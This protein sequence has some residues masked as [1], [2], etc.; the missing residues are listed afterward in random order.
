[1][2]SSHHSMYAL[3]LC[4]PQLTVMSQYGDGGSLSRVITSS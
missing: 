4:W 2:V 1:M 3:L